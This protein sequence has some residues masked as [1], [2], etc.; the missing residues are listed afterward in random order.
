MPSSPSSSPPGRRR[1][2]T[3]VGAVLALSVVAVIVLGQLSH[4]VLA[5]PPWDH[6]DRLS[7][8]LAAR[9]PIVAA[10]AV[11]RLAARALAWY[12][13]ATTLAGVLA[14]SLG[15]VRAV[16]MLDVT[17]PATLRRALAGITT[18]SLLGAA[19]T[20][21]ASAAVPVAIALAPPAVPTLAPPAPPA[22]ITLAPPAA[23]IPAPPGPDWSTPVMRALPPPSPWPPPAQAPP[24][25]AP[26]AQRP[27]AQRPPAQAP[28]AQAPP[29]A[30]PAPPQPPPAPAHW[31]VQPGDN[32]WSVADR[33]LARRWGRPP[34]DAEVDSYWRA[35]ISDNRERLAQP[36]WPDLIFPGQVLVLPAPP[37]GGQQT[38]PT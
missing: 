9:G 8:W 33:A 4:G 29:P 17:T 26:P 34:T 14:R 28:P 27:P 38:P 18:I 30:A 6:P 10:F 32:L 31:V 25:Q 21:T 22:G 5:P 19:T 1:A 12:L 15:L 23:P 20:G 7:G 35:V 13:L 2:I 3:C 11:L 36:G 24:A 16:R 37:P